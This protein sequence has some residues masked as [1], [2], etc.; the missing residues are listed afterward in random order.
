MKAR[1]YKVLINLVNA[2][3]LL[4][5]ALLNKGVSSFRKSLEYLTYQQKVLLCCFFGGSN[6]FLA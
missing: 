6:K 5:I 1:R 3:K 2:V 4:S